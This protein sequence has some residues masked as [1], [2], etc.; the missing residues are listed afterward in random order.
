[1]KAMRMVEKFLSDREKEGKNMANREFNIWLAGF[2]DSIANYGY[3]VDFKKVYKNVDKIK[4][5]LNILNSLIGS[6]NIETDF[7]NLT[8]Y[9]LLIA[10]ASLL[11]DLKIQTFLLRNIKYLCAKLDC[12]I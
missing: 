11:M 12:L 6:K 8:R 7:D 10:T 9:T 5:E 2:R 4:V 3:Y 1:M